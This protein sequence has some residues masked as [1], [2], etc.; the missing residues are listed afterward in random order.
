MPLLTC[1]KQVG[2]IIEAGAKWTV[3]SYT[4]FAF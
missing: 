2:A 4:A 1:R 3:A